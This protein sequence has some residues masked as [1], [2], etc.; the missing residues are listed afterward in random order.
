MTPSTNAQVVR[1]PE[2]LREVRE[3]NRP[4]LLAIAATIQ[5]AIARSSK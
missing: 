2:I 3:A 1:D 4:K 5:Q